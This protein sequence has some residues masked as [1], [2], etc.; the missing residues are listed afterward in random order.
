MHGILSAEEVPDPEGYQ[1]CTPGRCLPTGGA[2]I[3]GSGK[4][5]IVVVATWGF[6]NLG[7]LQLKLKLKTGKLKFY[8]SASAQ[9]YGQ[10]AGFD[11]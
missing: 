8:S 3:A 2:V 1:H 11:C 7:L 10:V 5:L 4:W 6:H 9:V